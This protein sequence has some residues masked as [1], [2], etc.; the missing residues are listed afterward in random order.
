V[1]A[2]RIIGIAGGQVAFDGPPTE[3]DEDALK[4][5]YQGSAAAFALTDHTMYANREGAGHP[6]TLTE[7]EAVEAAERLQ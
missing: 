4:R 7:R 2:D 3:L 1:F 5:V 6:F